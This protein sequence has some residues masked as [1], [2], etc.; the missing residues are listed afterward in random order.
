MDLEAPSE[1]GQSVLVVDDDEDVRHVVCVVLE[2]EGFTVIEAGDGAAALR[3]V[4][5]GDV[6]IV[7]LDL[8]LPDMPGLDLL[9]ELR[10]R[11]PTVSV[12]VLTGAGR[13]EDRVRGLLSGADD[14]MVKPFPTRELAARV[15]AAARRHRHPA[16]QAIS[17]GDLRIDPAAR[18]VSRGTEVI[19]LTRR[20]FDLLHLLGSNP[21]RTFTRD[22]LLR[23]AWGSSATWQS[24]ATVTEHVRRLRAKVERDPRQPEHII[25][26]RGI[27]YRFEPGITTAEPVAP[28]A[29]AGAQAS[30]DASVVLVGRSI[31]Y[32][33]P[34]ALTLLGASSEGEIVGHDVFEFVAEQSVAATSA[35]HESAKAGRWPR[36]ELITILLR[37]GEEVLVELASTSVVWE[38]E[39]ASQITMWELAGDTARLR[40]L[41]TGVRTDVPDAVIITDADYRIQ[42][43]NPAA[44]ELYGW[45][46][47]DLLGRFVNDVIPWAG[48]ERDLERARQTLE[49]DGRWHGEAIQRRRDGRVLQTLASTTVLRDGT[50]RAVGVISVN[51]PFP[52]G[53]AATSSR[54]DPEH[55]Y[56]IQQALDRD[57]FVVHF[58]P[59]VR[60]DDA[61]HIGMEALVRWQHP[62]RGLLL[63]GSFLDAAEATDMIVQLEQVVIEKACRQAA[64]WHDAGR[65]L[66]VA[67]N[68]SGRQLADE[69]LPQRLERAM[70]DASIAPG[71]LWLEV[72]ETSLVQDLDKASEL[73][74]RIDALGVRISID[75]FGTGWAS[76]TYLQTFPVHALKID[77]TFVQE[78]GRTS[79]GSTI[80]ASIISLG[81]ELG[82]AVVAEGIETA[83][84]R[85]RLQDLG[86]DLGQGYLFGRP[87]AADQLGLQQRS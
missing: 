22:Q 34:S 44:E 56:R 40:E 66:Y 29:S 19:E 10:D 37:S 6:D 78:L 62:E 16:S 13:E 69:D 75:D 31:V 3:T 76:L 32:A 61:S 36:P 38:G 72:T 55:E 58:Q 64:S 45:L 42:S 7:V 5:E 48:D 9:R 73:L 41:A 12:I 86:C 2:R 67:V 35:R 63:P 18:L 85:T 68:V 47:D 87:M 26:V 20:E 28:P 81:H 46:E 79:R 14:Y 83:G 82:L 84:Q 52:R 8:H 57:E 53:T 39:P 33:S 59:V 50:G 60:L 11:M 49:A 43:V 30:L 65:D 27:G 23:A 4:T 80:V 15:N 71:Q 21:R 51:R 74:Q 77:R 24:A 70:A 1:R 17:H 54:R 25:T